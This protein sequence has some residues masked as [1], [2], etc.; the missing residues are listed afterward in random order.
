M[1]GSTVYKKKGGYSSVVSQNE[2]T[3]VFKLLRVIICTLENGIAIRS[4]SGNLKTCVV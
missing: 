1:Q 3:W 4:I 2:I